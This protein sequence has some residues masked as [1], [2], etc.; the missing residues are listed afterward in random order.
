MGLNPDGLQ[1]SSECI[2]QFEKLL[3]ESP[4]DGSD[5][6][7]AGVSGPS[8]TFDTSKGGVEI[9]VGRDVAQD[10]FGGGVKRPL[11]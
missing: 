5:S 7:K 6:M 9:D 11:E 4:A 3:R 10:S 8:V 2:D 1:H